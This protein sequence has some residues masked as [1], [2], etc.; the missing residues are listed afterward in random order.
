MNQNKQI[1]SKN[2]GVSDEFENQ[3]FH[4]LVE[5]GDIMPETEAEVRAAE[6]RVK[7]SGKTL[8]KALQDAKALLQ[9]IKD[10][11]RNRSSKVVPIPSSHFAEVGE[12]LARAARKGKPI[13]AEIEEK[14]RKNR[15]KSDASDNGNSK[16]KQA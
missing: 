10:K 3:V 7:T 4:T 8:P 1:K 13:P 16:D 15:A 11:K 14:M 9:R 5:R 6:N 12:E 2:V